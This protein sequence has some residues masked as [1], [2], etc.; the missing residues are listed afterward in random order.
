MHFAK[1][2]L[3]FLFSTKINSPQTLVEIVK[4]MDIHTN[5]FRKT[6]QNKSAG[7]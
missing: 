4:K 2:Y 1:A 5:I 3:S 6:P 7:M